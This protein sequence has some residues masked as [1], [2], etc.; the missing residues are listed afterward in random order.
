[1]VGEAGILLKRG[2]GNVERGMRNGEWENKKLEQNL[3]TKPFALSVTSLVM[4]ALF[5]SH[6]S[7]SSFPF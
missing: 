3:V 4:P 7:L 1:M 2:T 5:S 6:F